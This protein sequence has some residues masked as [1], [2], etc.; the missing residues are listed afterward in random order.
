MWVDTQSLQVMQYII[1]FVLEFR[2][3]EYLAWKSSERLFNVNDN[4]K[5]NDTHCPFIL[6]YTSLSTQV[7]VGANLN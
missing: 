2:A 5:D 7:L 1:I 4:D 6:L 3:L